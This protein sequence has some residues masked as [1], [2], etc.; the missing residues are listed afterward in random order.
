MVRLQLSRPRQWSLLPS[1]QS[2]GHRQLRA[3]RAARQVEGEDDGAVRGVGG[4]A[5]Q[6]APVAG[7]RIR[8]LADADARVAVG[9]E[10]ALA[11][12]VGEAARAGVCKAVCARSHMR[13]CQAH[14][15][16]PPTLP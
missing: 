9:G 15:R 8:G 16:R 3:G 5:G 12:G 14:R 4:Q 11:A 6:P 10:T 1:P 13:C 2:R 7:K